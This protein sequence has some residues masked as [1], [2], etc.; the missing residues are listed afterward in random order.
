MWRHYEIT[1]FAMYQGMGDFD[2]GVWRIGLPPCCACNECKS[3][4][5]AGWARM[6]NAEMFP[7]IGGH[8]GS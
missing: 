6:K 7:S 8:D 3:A 1:L 2:D 5:A 4:Y